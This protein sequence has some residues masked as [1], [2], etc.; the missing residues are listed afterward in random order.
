MMLLRKKEREPFIIISIS[1]ETT[2]S[3][4]DGPS[5]SN[6]V[7]LAHDSWISISCLDENSI[8]FSDWEYMWEFEEG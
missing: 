7:T 5:V 2:R 1:S 4:D 8:G 6:S 3:V